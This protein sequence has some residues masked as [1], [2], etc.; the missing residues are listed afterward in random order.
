L[1]HIYQHEPRKLAILLSGKYGEEAVYT[2]LPKV[3]AAAEAQVSRLQ[4]Q[5]GY[6]VF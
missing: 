3:A 5:K 2:Y 1:D 4:V 6:T